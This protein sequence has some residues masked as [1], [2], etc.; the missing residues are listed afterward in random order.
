MLQCTTKWATHLPGCIPTLNHRC[1]DA[2]S[3]ATK[4][5]SPVNMKFQIRTTSENIIRKR[6]AAAVRKMNL[7]STPK[8][9][10]SGM[11]KS[12]RKN[13][14]GIRRQWK[15]RTALSVLPGSYE[16]T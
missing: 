8:A 6:R 16:K 7:K 14:P 9:K 2:L 12:V 3:A 5:K 10:L 11:A 4:S 15:I 13:T 1:I